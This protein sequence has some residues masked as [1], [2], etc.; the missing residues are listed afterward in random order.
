MKGRIGRDA[1][2]M[3]GKRFGM[4]T[5]VQRTGSDRDGNAAW[6]FVCDCGIFKVIVGYS[7]RKGDSTSCG[8]RARALTSRRAA[9]H[10]AAKPRKRTPEYR[11]WTAMK[12]R[13]YNPKADSYMDYGGRGIGVC[14][15]WRSSFAAFLAHVGRRPGDGWSLDRID[16]ERDY[17]P[18]NVRWATSTEQANNRRSTT[19]VVLG[20]APEPFADAC[21]RTGLPTTTVRARL[22]LGWTI[23]RAFGG[24]KCVQG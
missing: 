3:V 15:E 17:E 7:V 24:G 6:L 19:F 5:C 14:D 13:C 20:G 16:T 22:R 2:D 21:R 4:L 12:T 11:A 9:S 8:C 10:G 23:E 1:V 18:G